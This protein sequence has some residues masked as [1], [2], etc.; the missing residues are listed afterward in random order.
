[1]LVEFRV[2]NAPDAGAAKNGQGVVLINQLAA[3]LRDQI[4]EQNLFVG[5][6]VLTFG[7]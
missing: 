5:A 7:F 6:E 2:D 3:M 1:M 4:K